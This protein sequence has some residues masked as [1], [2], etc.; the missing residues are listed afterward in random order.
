MKKNFINKVHLEGILY[1]HSLEMKTSGPNTKKPGTQ[2]ISGNISIATDNDIT[3]IVPVHF[4][5]VTA[6]TTAGNTNATFTFL[7]DIIDGKIGTYMTD[8]A[9]KAGKIRV[10]TALSLNEFYS[11]RNGKEEFVSAKRNEG[12]FAHTTVELADTDIGRNN[13]ECDMLI[14]GTFR[15]PADE[16]KGTVEKLTLKGAIF[17][18]RKSLLPVEFSVVNPAAMDYFEGLEAS[19]S[20][21]VFTKVYGTQVSE[22][23]IRKQVEETAFGEPIVRETKN[24]R[25]DFVIY[26]AI[27]EPYLWDDESTMTAED[28]KKAIADREIYLADIKRRQD[29]YKASKANTAINIAPPANS[30]FNF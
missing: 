10:D 4:T 13:F 1:E 3:N 14:T 7:K 27:K 15:T 28:L 2:F 5:Y 11:D 12:G 30:P 26:N 29:E 20:A 8:G 18:F 16:E 19:Q 21:P 24:T 22:V 23:V 6:T 9:E 25:K 17:D